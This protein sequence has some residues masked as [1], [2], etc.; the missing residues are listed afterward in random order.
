MP[1]GC[2][3]ATRLP[4]SRTNVNVA[5][6]KQHHIVFWYSPSMKILLVGW[7]GVG[8]CCSAKLIN[9]SSFKILQN[10]GTA[11]L[12]KGYATMGTWLNSN[13]PSQHPFWH[14]M[15]PKKCVTGARRAQVPVTRQLDFLWDHFWTLKL[16]LWNLR[17]A[18]GL[19]SG[20][21]SSS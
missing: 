9:S 16:P 8:K 14:H 7:S 6:S 4:N 20:P 5:S 13:G 2:K 1:K 11:W 3:K 21:R 12:V 15:G 10:I 17:D 19:P 18:P